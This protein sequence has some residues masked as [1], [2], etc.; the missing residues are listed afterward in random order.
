[1]S[2]FFLSIGEHSTLNTLALVAHFGGQRRLRC[3]TFIE[4]LLSCLAN[5][6]EQSTSNLETF[7]G[8]SACFR[9]AVF[10]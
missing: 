8:H 6:A 4:Q 3:R 5:R 1:M 7:V 10:R 9:G 2:R